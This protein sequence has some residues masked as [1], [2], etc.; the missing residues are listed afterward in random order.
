MFVLFDRVIFGVMGFK[1]AGK[2]NLFE[3]SGDDSMKKIDTAQGSADLAF[4][5]TI[6]F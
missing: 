2:L 6:R 1:T 3:L 4:G 5:V